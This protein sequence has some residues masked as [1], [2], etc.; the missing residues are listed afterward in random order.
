MHPIPVQLPCLR[1]SIGWHLD[2]HLYNQLLQT[3]IVMSVMPPG[4]SGTFLA[5]PLTGVESHMYTEVA[6]GKSFFCSINC[7]NKWQS[8]GC[9]CFLFS[10]GT[11][12]FSLDVTVTMLTL[13]VPRVAQHQGC[14]INIKYVFCPISFVHIFTNHSTLLISLHLH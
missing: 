13:H 4:L 9:F 7:D 14:Q 12:F 8:A 10:E 1:C 3:H 11:L 6:A 2:T 5:K